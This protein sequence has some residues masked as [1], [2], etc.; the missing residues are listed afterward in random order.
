MVNG[1]FREIRKA[2]CAQGGAEVFQLM[3]EDIM[4]Y[5]VFDINEGRS[6]GASV[7]ASPHEHQLL[8]T[9]LCVCEDLQADP[10]ANNSIRLRS[11]HEQ[12]RNTDLEIEAYLGAEALEPMDDGIRTCSMHFQFST[13]QV[14]SRVST[15]TPP[16]T[17]QTMYSLSAFR[18]VAC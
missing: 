16:C 10:G 17:I 3:E 2:L 7:L 1:H 5:I 9:K 13:P 11:G 15:C 4:R 8:G 12:C 6:C 18:T 14:V